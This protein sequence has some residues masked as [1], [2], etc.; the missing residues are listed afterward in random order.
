METPNE[1][2]VF[3]MSNYS[4]SCKQ[5]LDRIAFIAPHFNTKIINIDNPET[6]DIVLNST[7]YKIETVPAV[8]LIYP[9]LNQIQHRLG[10]SP[11]KE[12]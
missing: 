10:K 12:H 7:T 5:I 4:N 11:G 6:R 9:K 1:I 2:F 3:F 8:L